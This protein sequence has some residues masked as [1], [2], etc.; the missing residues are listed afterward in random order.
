VTG[1]EDGGAPRS[2]RILYV[3]VL[4]LVAAGGLFTIVDWAR[5][6]DELPG[7]GVPVTGRVVEERPGFAGALAL[8]EVIYEAGGRERRARLPVAGSDRDPRVATFEPGD[9]IALLVSRTDPERVHQVGW[10][11]DTADGPAIPAWLLVGIAVFVITPLVLRGPRQRLQ[12]ALA[13]ALN[14]GGGRGI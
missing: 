4:G 14:S 1:V 8:V 6:G 11:A 13:R 3:V 7:G 12:A 2:L 9:P 10:G 5:R